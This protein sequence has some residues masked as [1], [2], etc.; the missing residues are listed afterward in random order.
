MPTKFT[1]RP[2]CGERQIESYVI[3]PGDR[4]VR[5]EER[6]TSP[7]PWSHQRPEK[8]EWW[9]DANYPLNESG[10]IQTEDKYIENIQTKIL[11]ENK[12]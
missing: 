4:C 9:D 6:D 11:Q 7:P 1:P 5:M 3:I 12:S 10:F 2:Q 8:I